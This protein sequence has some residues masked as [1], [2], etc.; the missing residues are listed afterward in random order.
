MAL[1]CSSWAT[2]AFKSVTD[3]DDIGSTYTAC[4]SGMWA[5]WS[6]NHHYGS[7]FTPTCMHTVNKRTCSGAWYSAWGSSHNNPAASCSGS[8]CNENGGDAN[9][10]HTLCM[11]LPGYARGSISAS[12]CTQCSSGQITNTLR[13]ACENC[14]AGYYCTRPDLS[15]TAC[16]AVSRYCPGGKS[17]YYTVSTGHYTTGGGTTTRTGQSV[18]SV[19]SCG[20][21]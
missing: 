6:F 18:C 5:V 8:S 21:Y 2:T 7:D 15:A 4:P 16:G 14:P 13:T 3:I 1:F 9:I 10:L 17:T 20:Q 19:S 11:C 12:S